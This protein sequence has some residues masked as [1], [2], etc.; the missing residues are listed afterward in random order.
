M[1]E[2]GVGG[3]EGLWS[4]A[5]SDK[6]V[7][8]YARAMAK[9]ASLLGRSAWTEKIDRAFTGDTLIRTESVRQIRI[10]DINIYEDEYIRRFSER[11]GFAWLRTPEVVCDHLRTYNLKE[12]YEAGKYAHYFG[13]LSASK[14]IK[15]L[16]QLPVKLAFCLA[17]TRNLRA[18]TFEVKR[19]VRVLQ[20]FIH[21]HAQGSISLRFSP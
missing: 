5:L 17:Y 19:E 18:G 21:A 9:L 13:E 10:P 7:D 12:A 1:A 3:I 4:Y 6:R 2:P 8:D 14:E 11:R 15:R 16:A 20:G